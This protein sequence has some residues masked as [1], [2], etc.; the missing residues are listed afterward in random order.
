MPIDHVGLGVPD[1]EIAK[2]YYDELMPMVGFQPCFGNGYCPN[3]WNGAQLFL[4]ESTEDGAYSRHHS[5]LQHL[6]FLVAT[7]EEV[8]TVH[9]WVRDRGDE[10]LHAPRPFPQF[11]EHCY[12]TYF[13][14]PHGF[15][16][17]VV[18]QSPAAD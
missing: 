16:L 8:D 12:A 4:Y 9:A 7:R 15:K 3:D 13:L 17:E 14:D 1:M 6:A 10:V 18:C 2:A 5:G 11:G